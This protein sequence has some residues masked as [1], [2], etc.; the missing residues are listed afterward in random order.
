MLG[1]ING[2][3]VKDYL[4]ITVTPL[5]FFTMRGF[6]AHFSLKKFIFCSAIRFVTKWCM[7]SFSPVIIVPWW[8]GR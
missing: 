7:P 3:K 5:F 4:T 2:A 8:F 6:L 1:R